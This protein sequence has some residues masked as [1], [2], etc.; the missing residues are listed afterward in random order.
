[1]NIISLG[2]GVQSFTLAAMSALEQLPPVTAAVHAD[3]THER[4]ETYAFAERW[5]PWLEQRGVK[6]VTVSNS[7]RFATVD[8]WG[9][10]F[11]P[12]FTTWLDG[13][14]S[15]QLR[16]QCTHR[17]KIVPIRRWSAAQLKRQGLPKSPGII[18]QWLGITL[19][20]VQRVKPSDVNYVK[21][22]FPFLELLDRPWTRSDAT[23]WLQEQELEIP[24]KS[25]CMFCPY[26]NRATW[27]QIQTCG[28]GDWTTATQVD[29]AIRTKRPG[30]L[31]YVCDQR[32]PLTQC[33][34]SNEED[35]GQLPLF[36]QCDS[37]YCFT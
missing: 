18:N 1:M 34:F 7:Q 8:Q 2:W 13:S 23:R 25:S 19:D 21:N 4:S 20:E 17:W 29:Q 14:K 15:G 28:N 16:R 12:A 35:H 22:V 36:D 31:A 27:R 37:G 32:Q 5:T 24:V 30:Y 6:V 3:T 10:V 26:H 11:I 9:G 33:D